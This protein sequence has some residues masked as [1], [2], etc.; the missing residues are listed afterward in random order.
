MGEKNAVII[1]ATINNEDHGLLSAWVHLNYGG[2]GQGFGGYNL[3]APKS[4]GEGPNLCGLFIW[5]VLEVVGV[6]KWED[7][8][9]K[10]IRVSATNGGVD[11][12]GH[13]VEDKWFWPKKEFE[14]ALK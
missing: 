4:Q 5:R 7:L 10:T 8:K 1:S 12:I 3:Y 14:A 11:A 13:I 9:G 2:S 6:G